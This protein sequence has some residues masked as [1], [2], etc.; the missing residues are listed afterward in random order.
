MLTQVVMH[1]CARLYPRKMESGAETNFTP[2][3]ISDKT[4]EMMGGLEDS[5]QTDLA[6][7]TIIVL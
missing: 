5:E 7:R 1:N 2:G 4:Q 6:T 3:H